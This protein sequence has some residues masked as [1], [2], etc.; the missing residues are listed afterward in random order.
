VLPLEIPSDQ[1]ERIRPIVESL[2]ARLRAKARELPPN[3]DSALRF[4]PSIEDGK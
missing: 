1:L 3:T 2:L 4:E